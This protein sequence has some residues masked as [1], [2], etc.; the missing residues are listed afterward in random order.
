MLTY[1]FDDVSPV[2]DIIKADG[3]FGPELKY[4]ASDIYEMINVFG[5][6]EWALFMDEIST[7]R[8]V[9]TMNSNP[10]V[11]DFALVW[12]IDPKAVTVGLGS[13]GIASVCRI[14]AHAILM[15]KF[16]DTDEVH[17]YINE[18]E[19]QDGFSYWH[20]HFSSDEAI[21]DRDALIADY[22]T[23]NSPF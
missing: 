23:Y 15:A 3:K 8:A 10:F 2:V 4:Q 12:S 6:V 7:I 19:H 13:V 20:N 5:G 17:D 16:G 18:A 21:I 22:E 14:A 1:L 9:D 11:S